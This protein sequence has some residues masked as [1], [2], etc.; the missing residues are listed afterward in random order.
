MFSPNPSRYPSRFNEYSN[1]NSNNN[2]SIHS[3][4]SNNS[5][6]KTRVSNNSNI[7]P[8]VATAANN[9]LSAY[10]E[11]PGFILSGQN[12]EDEKLTGMT[13]GERFAGVSAAAKRGLN[14]ITDIFSS[15]QAG[16]PV[17]SLGSISPASSAISSISSQGTISSLLG[18]NEK[19]VLQNVNKGG[20]R[21]KRTRKN[22]SKKNK[23]KKNKN[24]NRK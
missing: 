8:V 1:S 14:S 3:N 13:A 10:P 16:S 21:N 11:S 22:K 7:T 23:S 12:L 15:N 6:N 9:S 24:R 2:R 20:R 5:N 18:N 17:S 4:N 19:P